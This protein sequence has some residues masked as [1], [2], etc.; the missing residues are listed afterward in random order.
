M[1]NAWLKVPNTARRCLQRVGT[2][3]DFSIAKKWRTADNPL[4]SV[5]HLLP[6]HKDRERHFAA[7]P[8][9]EVPALMATLLDGSPSVPRY[10]MAFSILTAARPNEVRFMLWKDVDLD[11]AVWSI[12]PEKMKMGRR[13][14]VPLSSSALAI[15]RDVAGLFGGKADELVFP[16]RSEASATRQDARTDSRG[17]AAGHHYADAG[18]AT[19]R[20]NRDCSWDSALVVFRLGERMHAVQES[21]DRKC[22][23][24]RQSRSKRGGVSANDV[25][26]S[27]RAADGDVVSVPAAAARRQWQRSTSSGGPA[28]GLGKRLDWGA[29]HDRRCHCRI[30]VCPGAE[31]AKKGRSRG[32]SR[33][34]RGACGRDV[35][36]LDL[37]PRGPCANV[38]PLL[39]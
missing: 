28:D 29:S 9:L 10:A 24:A 16:G 38:T 27:A 15:L 36:D 13:H 39:R 12:P 11:K 20:A 2:V 17:P 22:A 8:Y 3:L 32:S 14:E 19:D 25:F 18:H 31:R 35:A 34:S 37:H 30:S 5:R 23:R 21:C 7:V 1:K 33:T 4:R 6:K 26:R